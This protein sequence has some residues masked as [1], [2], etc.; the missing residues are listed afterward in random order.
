MTY[1]SKCGMPVS[2]GALCSG[3]QVVTV[4]PLMT[5]EDMNRVALQ[6]VLTQKAHFPNAKDEEIQHA[7]NKIGR[8]LW[9]VR[10]WQLPRV[11]GEGS[12]LERT[13]KT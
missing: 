11:K 9:S 13:R 5:L 4:K 6:F 10:R 12:H 2:G 1:C 3:G 8:A 7:A